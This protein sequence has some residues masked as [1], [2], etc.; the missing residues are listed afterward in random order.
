MTPITFKS[1][2]HI[3]HSELFDAGGTPSGGAVVIA[4]GSDG[5]TDNLSG[6]W[7]IMIRDYAKELSLKG[8]TVLVPF[9]FER[10]NT[11]P[12]LNA[13]AEI[14]THRD[15]WQ[16]T[17]A[18][19]IAHVKTLTGVDASRIG[20]LGFSLGGHLCLRLRASAKVL[21]EFFAPEGAE[22]GGLGTVTPL[23]LHAQ[24]HH[25]MDD[26]L[27]PPS[28]ATSIESLLKREGASCE[29]FLYPGA[30]HGFAG[31]AAGDPAA[32]RDSKQHTL[33]FIQKYL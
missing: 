14:L 10:T 9:Y 20:L 7:G 5:M 17:V 15:L 18:D 32:R 30:G 31:P 22:Y 2:G 29:R 16:A 24:I 1:S 33:D 21:V 25:G 3:I 26:H 19:A 23:S 28:N 8:F 27:V 11:T 12:G 6:P 13:M 4:H